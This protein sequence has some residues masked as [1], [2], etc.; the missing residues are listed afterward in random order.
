[1]LL[2]ASLIVLGWFTATLL[3]S[4]AYFRSFA[5]ARPPIGVFNLTDVT[6]MVGG[7]VLVPYLFLALPSW[8]LVGLLALG[9]ISALSAALE[10]LLRR[11][12]LV[13]GATLLIV[14]VVVLL[15]GRRDALFYAANNLVLLGMAVGL[16]NL[17]A[18]S[19]LR[20]RDTAI[21]AGALT[22]Y[23]IV[24]TSLLPLMGDLFDRLSGLPLAPLIAW[25]VDG[26][27]W[28]GIGL[29]DLLVA[30]VFP[31]VMRKAFGQAAGALALLSGVA[32]CAALLAAA[33]LGLL[34]V[35]FPVMVVLGPL[36][37]AQYAFWRR[38]GAERTTQQYLQAEPRLVG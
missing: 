11:S 17:W 27:R 19:G 28:L 29:G 35:T 1:M 38:R 13:W 25:P 9:A 10:P 5:L 7:V 21:L 36:I 20:V 24:A 34:R 15:A 26:G 22:V 31:L 3:L 14:G 12:W 6:L 23:D 33:L 8:L 37:L 2:T 30:A 4:L 32:T 18:Q 16:S